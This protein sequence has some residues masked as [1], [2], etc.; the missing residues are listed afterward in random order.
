MS[1]LLE[2]DRLILSAPKLVEVPELYEF[3][4]DKDA[5]QYT[6]CDAS[7]AECRRRIAVHEWKRRQD[8]FAPW[9]IREKQTEKA[10]GW[11]G[12]YEDP[13][14]PGWGIELAYYFRPSVWGQGYATEL[15]RA[16]LEVA[17]KQ[18]GAET[19]SAFADPRNT[20][21]NALLKKMGFKYRRFIQEMNRNLYGRRRQF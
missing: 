16:A 19:V 5:M 21:S 11:G 8:G 7:I 17:D 15:C 20:A 18:V 2:T 12:L 6:H 3:L 9:T 1:K 10:I 4:G 13:F 14:D